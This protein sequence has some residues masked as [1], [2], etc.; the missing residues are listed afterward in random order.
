MRKLYFILLIAFFSETTFSQNLENKYSFQIE[1]K[2][3]MEAYSIIENETDY[4]FF[5]NTNWFNDNEELVNVTFSESTINE[6][7]DALFSSSDFNYYIDSKKIIITKNIGIET[8]AN[9]NILDTITKQKEVVTKKS[10]PYFFKQE[11]KNNPAKTYF[12]G[13]EN[14]SNSSKKFYIR[15]TITNSVTGEPLSNI[16]IFTSD[17][18]NYTVSD[19]DGNYS[20]TLPYG[21]HSIEMQSVNY[22][23]EYDKE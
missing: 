23:K 4:I 7:M 20:I 9:F 6:I 15:G 17:K 3:L 11:K 12:I 16:A 1:N 14:K 10:E 18:K 21:K 13:Q 19:M 5:Y 2:K 22:E 8:F